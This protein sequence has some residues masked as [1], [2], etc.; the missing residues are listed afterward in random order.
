MSRNF[1][2]QG[3]ARLQP[4]TK[5][6]TWSLLDEERGALLREKDKKEIP[7]GVNERLNVA[8]YRPT[9]QDGTKTVTF[10]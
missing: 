7:N 1:Q 5:E 2:C 4:L 10:P 6:A 9:F 3:I 8:R